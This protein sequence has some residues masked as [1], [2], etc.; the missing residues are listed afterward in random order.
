MSRYRHVDAMKA[1][2]F[3][4][5]AACRAAEV[6]SA[7]YYEWR[8][9]DL[10]GPSEATRAEVELVAEIREIHTEL[11]K[12]YGSPRVTRELKRRGRRVNH[13][14]VERLMAENDIAGVTERRRVRTTIPAEGAPPLPDLVER[15]FSPGAPDV[16]W[17]G[18]ITYIGT[19]EGWLYL[20]SVLDLGS[21]RLIGWQ[22]DDNMS[23]PLVADALAMAVEL[24]GGARGV[25]F[26]S[27]RGS[28]YLSG[29]YRGLCE[30]HGIRQSA[31][32]VAT[33][34]DN[35]VAEAFWSSLK[36]ELVHRFRFATRAQARAAVEAWIRRY[37]AVRL[38]SSL[39]YVPP[40]EW[41]LNYRRSQLQQ[42]A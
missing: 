2:G 5:R 22:M 41:E 35:S 33:C 6:S 4:V 7:A 32:R 34:F 23:T 13:K 42:A 8:E 19:D 39:D 30:H 17:A 10:A 37:N 14:R 16:A 25:T 38:H 40:I 15:R 31:G 27:D 18:D 3:A 29:T 28:Q 12:S 26:H 1:E 20:S 9:R 21:R 11:D 24:R 36:R